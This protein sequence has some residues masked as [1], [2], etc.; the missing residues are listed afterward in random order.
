MTDLRFWFD[1]VCPFA[2]LTSRWVEEVARR[3]EYTVE[4]RFISLR[5]LNAHVDY[6]THFPPEY[7]AGHTAGLRLLRVAARVRDQHGDDGVGRF[8]TGVGQGIH[9]AEPTGGTPGHDRR[10]TR[11]FLAPVL[12]D[13]GL[14][15]DLADALDDDALDAGIQAETDEAL[16]LAGKD[17]GTPILQFLPPDGLAFFGPVISRLPA[18]EDA[19][20]LWDHVVGLASFPGF[21]ELKR[22]L[23]ERPQ[24]RSFGVE[25]GEVGQTEDWHGGSRRQKR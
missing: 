8:Y 4:W 2:W 10:G 19:V 11:D 18:P 12:A 21:T 13:L 1:P 20:A 16:A 14:A 24:L 7:E 25:P 5:L 17:V 22:S 15:P 6:A 3:R 23:R 9:D